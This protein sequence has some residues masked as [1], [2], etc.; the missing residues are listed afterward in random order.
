MSPEQ[1]ITPAPKRPY[2]QFGLTEQE[3]L[4]WRVRQ[5][6]FQEI[7]ED[8][9]TLIHNIRP[10]SNEYGEFL[11]V[12]TSRPGTQERIFITFY[13]LGYHNS[14]E[15]WI[16]EEWFWYNDSPLRDI[17]QNIIPKQHAKDILS[18]RVS[19]IELSLGLNTQTAF[20]A[21]YEMLADL[22]DEDGAQAEM[23]DLDA[24]LSDVEQQIPPEETQSIEESLLDIASRLKLPMLR[25]NEEL[26]L[27]ALAQVK[28]FTPDG[29]WAWYASEF[30][31]HDTFWG[32][33]SGV[34]LKFDHFSLKVLKELRGPKG[35][36]IKRDDHF[37]PKP[38]WE[39]KQWHLDQRPDLSDLDRPF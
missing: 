30:D 23:E 6:R 31:G 17:Q 28:F 15:R 35:L 25:A 26:E 12:T 14:R 38:L 39:L 1:S 10:D 8:E 36:P 27:D 33:V 2:E 9:H 32:L 11:F 5:E 29:D 3:A 24:W 34:D 22:T 13:G 37:E 18:Q 20:G 7:L 16:S 4:F 19:E 21:L